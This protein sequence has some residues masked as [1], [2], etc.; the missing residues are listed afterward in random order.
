MK[1]IGILL[2]TVFGFSFLIGC[3][4]QP[5]RADM[6]I[7]Q[8]QQAENDRQAKLKQESDA[9][10]LVL[11]PYYQNYK[12]NYSK[13][14]ALENQGSIAGISFSKI[15]IIDADT[16]KATGP[17]IVFQFKC[18]DFV[19]VYSKLMANDSY[20]ASLRRLGGPTVEGKEG[21]IAVAVIIE[22]PSKQRAL[23]IADD[24]QLN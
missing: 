5:S 2:I 16:F 23:F 4:S 22:A 3:A 17:N 19:D 9:I 8:M 10:D 13:A 6:V 12:L 20:I 15:E 11:A 18:K 21:P 14:K 24:K 7:A 1:K